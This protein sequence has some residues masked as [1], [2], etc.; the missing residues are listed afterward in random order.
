MVGVDW[1]TL[2]RHLKQD[3]TPKKPGPAAPGS[4]QLDLMSPCH[5]ALH[6]PAWSAW[7]VKPGPCPQLDLMSP[8]SPAY[9]VL[10][11]FPALLVLLFGLWLALP[12]TQSFAC[13]CVE[14]GPPLEERAKA[15]VVFQG[16]AVSVREFPAIFGFTGSTDPTTI[17]FKVQTVWKGAAYP[18]R[19]VTTAR[20][21][22]SCGYP[23]VAGTEYVV[24]TLLGLGW[25]VGLCS[26]TRPLSQASRDLAD[27]G[28]GTPP[29]LW[30]RATLSFLVL[31][32]MGGIWLGQRQRHSNKR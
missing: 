16:E 14:P 15:A 8:Q 27:L 22:S 24:Y 7:T 30:N 2:Y 3:G 26:R 25:H 10:C 28:P 11:S 1:T 12:P 6:I 5:K 23:F 32:L 17:T 4:N 18:T 9:P 20:S 13:S 31:L 29:S 19:Y 21:G